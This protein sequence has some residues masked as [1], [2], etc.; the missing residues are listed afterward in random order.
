M[1]LANSVS[2]V[3]DAAGNVMIGNDPAPLSPIV[4]PILTPKVGT[5]LIL[6]NGAKGVMDSAGNVMMGD[7]LAQ[8]AGENRSTWSPTTSN[9]ADNS[10]TCDAEGN[11]M[12]KD[13]L[14]GPDRRTWTPTD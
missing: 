5:T 9:F 13:S 1:I 8:M 6:A 4:S 2:G 10:L 7:K 11:C 14:A 3:V 12:L